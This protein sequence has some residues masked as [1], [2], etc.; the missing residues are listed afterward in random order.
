MA[1]VSDEKRENAES[2]VVEMNVKAFEGSADMKKKVTRKELIDIM[3]QMSANI[4]DISNYLMADVNGM[5]RNHV[6][7]LQMRFQALENII[8]E[9]IGITPEDISKEVYRIHQEVI[10]KAKES[11]EVVQGE[12]G[13]LKLASDVETKEHE[14]EIVKNLSEK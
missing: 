12:D 7:P 13:E 10:K 6:F 2:N 11:G 9:K 4:G 1:N 14:K 5:Y 8:C 3:E